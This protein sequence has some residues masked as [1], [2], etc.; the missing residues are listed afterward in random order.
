M[1]KENNTKSQLR[2]L[3]QNDRISTEEYFFR[4]KANELNIN[5]Y[6]FI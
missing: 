4:L 2:K 1:I 6:K 5:T 3:W